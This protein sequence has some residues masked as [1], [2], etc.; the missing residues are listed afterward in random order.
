[1]EPFPVNALAVQWE[2]LCRGSDAPGKPWKWQCRS[3]E[4]S[5]VGKSQAYFESLREAVAD[6][7]KHGFRYELPPEVR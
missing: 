4:G 6:A 5:I 3:A 2:F 7:N 1:M